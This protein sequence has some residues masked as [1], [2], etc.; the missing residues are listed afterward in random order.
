MKKLMKK[1]AAWSSETKVGVVIGLVAIVFF[2]VLAITTG[3]EPP[4]SFPTTSS[5]ATSI[6]TSTPTTSIPVFNPLDEIMEKP[7]N[8]NVQTVRY[9]FET[10]APSEQLSKS[11][12]YYDGNYE[13][14][15]GMDFAINNTQ[16]TVI[17]SLSGEVTNKVN[18]PI[19]GLTV[20]VASENNIEIIY[21]SLSSS[22]LQIGQEI[23]K[24]D[25]IGKAGEAVFGSDLDTNHLHFRVK[26][27][28]EYVNPQKYFGKAVKDIKKWSPIIKK[29]VV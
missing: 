22:D 4:T 25:I 7:F 26:I 8:G 2:T 20:T 17:A 27:D 12:V 18:D 19:M 28:Q 1:V 14:S 21:S 29:E 6:T 24:G 10:D 16:F 11:V 5:Q 23:K 15:L 13:P 3:G 9:F